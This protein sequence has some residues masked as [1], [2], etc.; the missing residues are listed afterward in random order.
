M[1]T[2]VGVLDRSAR[3][4]LGIALLAWSYGR[5]GAP[6]SEAVAWL[7][8]VPAAAFAL[9]GLFRYCPLYAILGTHSCALYPDPD[10]D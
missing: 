10:G 3:L 8:W 1:L 6:L 4:V 5:I 9:T 7:V 2:N